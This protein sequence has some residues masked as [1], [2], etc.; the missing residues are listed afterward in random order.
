M[1]RDSFLL[2]AEWRVRPTVCLFIYTLPLNEEHP[3]QLWVG[4][5][6]EWHCK[7]KG[8]LVEIVGKFTLCVCVLVMCMMLY[9]RVLPIYFWLGVCAWRAYMPVCLH[10]CVAHGDITR[11]L[12]PTAHS[13]MLV[14]ESKHFNLIMSHRVVLWEY[15]CLDGSYTLREAPS[16]QLSLSSFF[17]LVYC[18][19]PYPVFLSS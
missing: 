2:T 18:S 4:L 10:A 1:V 13:S 12:F 15:Y 8:E 9:T 16:L 11:D 19:C 7:M 3:P 5:D 6:A 14:N 17:S